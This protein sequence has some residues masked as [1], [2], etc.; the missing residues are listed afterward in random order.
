MHKQGWLKL[1]HSQKLKQTKGTYNDLDAT[2][3][4]CINATRL[5]INNEPL[6]HKY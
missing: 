3:E 6:Q 2:T 5:Q 1:Y 4:R